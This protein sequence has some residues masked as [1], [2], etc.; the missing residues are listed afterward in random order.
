MS[1]IYKYNNYGELVNFNTNHLELDENSILYINECKS[2]YNIFNNMKK[3][4]K[5][6]YNDVNKYN[7]TV[8]IFHSK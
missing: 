1:I 8:I 7:D 4:K 3:L 2:Y 6:T 5:I